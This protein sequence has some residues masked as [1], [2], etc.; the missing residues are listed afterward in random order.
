MTLM[1]DKYLVIIFINLSSVLHLISAECFAT[2]DQ[3][4]S[5]KPFHEGIRLSANATRNIHISYTVTF[6]KDTKDTKRPIM[7]FRVATEGA[8]PP[9]ASKPC[10]S[11][12][13]NLLP[14]K[15][16]VFLEDN[17]SNC[18][19]NPSN[20]MITCSGIQAFVYLKPRQLFVN[21]G[22]EC[23]EGKPLNLSYRFCVSDVV[24]SECKALT[25]DDACKPFLND[26]PVYFPNRFGDLSQDKAFT[27]KRYF[28]VYSTLSKPDNKTSCYQHINQ[29]M[30]ISR[31][32]SCKPDGRY[33][34]PCKQMC[35]DLFSGC[36]DILKIEGII[37]CEN[38]P[39]G[40]PPSTP[41]VYEQ[42]I[43]PD[44]QDVA[45]GILNATG[46]RLYDTAKYECYSDLTLVGEK[47]LSC[48]PS[49][50][51]SHSQP[52]CKSRLN[53][54]IPIVA[55]TISV[56]LFVSAA[57]IMCYLERRFKLL[58]KRCCCCVG[59]NID[60]NNIPLHQIP[61]VFISFSS[62]D[63]DVVHTFMND[64]RVRIPE[65]EYFTYHDDF[66][67]G[68]A[69]VD[70][71]NKGVWE[72]SSAIIA[73]L[74]QDFV[75]SE[76]CRHEFDEAYKRQEQDR[77]FKLVIVHNMDNVQALVNVQKKLRAYLKN[78]IHLSL[79]EIYLWDRLKRSLCD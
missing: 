46:N 35:K 61:R 43:C 59:E 47:T 20:T 13:G 44:L 58:R 75:D 78:N 57:G 1:M 23:K 48:L 28:D 49:G 16:Y 56:F 50:L 31:Y 64:L 69:I 68:E 70:C 42:V 26:A 7:H 10:F 11:T 67:A 34:I 27:N 17:F 53:P 8:Q 60:N 2:S 79:N 6:P 19:H 9:P 63:C 39:D 12:P 5:D 14:N 76:W 21:F 77:N 29:F 52:T 40:L 32:P 36:K 71:I 3:L 66:L 55:G 62:Q 41:C 72:E 33:V 22:Y 15:Q 37:D 45:N 74:S 65:C 54:L 25:F 18:T 38:Y 24:R 4:H 30:C 51:W 73:F